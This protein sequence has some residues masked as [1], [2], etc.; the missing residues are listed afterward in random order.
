MCTGTDARKSAEAQST[1][2][3]VVWKL[4]DRGIPDEVSSSLGRAEVDMPLCR[5]RRQHEQL[6]QFERGRIIGMKK[7]GWSARRVARH[8]GR[9]D[10]VV[11]RCWDQWIR[12]MSFTRRPGSGRPQQTSRRE[13]HHIVRSACVQPNASSVAIQAQ[14]APSLGV[15]VSSRTIQRRLAEGHLGSRRPL[16][17]LPLTPTHRRLCLELCR[18]R[19]NWTAAEWN[20]VV[21]SDE[22]RFNLSSDD[23]RISVWRSRGERLNP[24]FALQRHTALKAGMIWVQLPTIHGHP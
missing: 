3:G 19:G 14:V 5:F 7:A 23:N 22:S 1:P 10:C 21:F 13:D 18:A 6:S 11:R 12:Q 2:V 16:S 17:V 9:F 4:G 20:Q 15:P 8:L 24:A